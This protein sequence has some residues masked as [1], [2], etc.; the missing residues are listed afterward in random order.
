MCFRLFNE[1]MI[2]C[3]N[4]DSKM[5]E[6]VGRIPRPDFT[7]SFMPNSCSSLEMDFDNACGLM[8]R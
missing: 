4:S 1:S 6:G 8:Y 2:S 3:D 5:A 7:K